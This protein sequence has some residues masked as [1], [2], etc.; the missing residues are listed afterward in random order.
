MQNLALMIHQ[1][2]KG[3]HEATA[4]LLSHPR[5]ERIN[6]SNEVL[7]VESQSVISEK[8]LFDYN[9]K[10]L[11]VALLSVSAYEITDAEKLCCSIFSSILVHREN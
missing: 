3:K 9:E 1:G 5:S 8:K 6:L 11:Q 4:T 2:S 10:P 7:L